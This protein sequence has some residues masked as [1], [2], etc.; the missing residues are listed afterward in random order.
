ML[1][2][3]A[4]VFVA[5]MAAVVLAFV[6][7][8]FGFKASPLEVLNALVPVVA[9]LAT[10]FVEAEP[11]G[12]PYFDYESGD[13]G[14]RAHVVATLRMPWGIE[15]LPD[16]RL[17]ITEKVGGLAIFDPAEGTVSAVGGTPEDVFFTGQG[18]LMDVALAG[19]F[20]QSGHIFLSYSVRTDDG[21]YSVRVVRMRLDLQRN[22]VLDLAE[23][24]LATPSSPHALN[25]GARLEVDPEGWLHVAM[26]D[27]KVRAAVQDPLSHLGTT[28]RY[29]ADGSLPP[30]SQ[31]AT[32]EAPDVLPELWTIGH[33]NVHGLFVHPETGDLWSTEHGEQGG[34][35]INILRGGANYGWPEISHSEEYGGGPIG[36]GSERVD[37]EAP[38]LTFTP[39]IAPTQLLFYKGEA[40]PEWNGELLV[41]TLGR[42][43]I[44]LN[45]DAQNPRAIQ[46]LEDRSLLARDRLRIRDI[47]L[48]K[49]GHIYAAAER[50]WIL[51]LE[52]RP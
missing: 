8:R 2:K 42:G 46:P 41:A 6:L 12:T 39:S 15:F 20:A 36:E 31:R 23:V 52:P 21:G 32:F 7:L 4:I 48:D 22:E 3:L 38:I 44:R 37:V 34:D 28:L 18:G 13:R 25:F 14:V 40:F 45:I 30:V 9:P 24:L 27:H 33:R 50:G 16:G 43:L 1:R 19:N 51:R 17:L 49:Q 35:E 5:F 11:I 26:S 10:D 47:A 29:A